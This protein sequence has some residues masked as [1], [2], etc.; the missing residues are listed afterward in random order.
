MGQFVFIFLSGRLGGAKASCSAR[1]VTVPCSIPWCFQAV[2]HGQLQP[3]WQFAS[4]ACG[5]LLGSGSWLGRAGGVQQHTHHLIPGRTEPKKPSG[6]QAPG[7]TTLLCPTQVPVPFSH[8]HLLSSQS[9][10]N[11][12]CGRTGG[13]RWSPREVFLL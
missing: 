5:M 1:E 8:K 6:G 13:R 10:Q 7:R 12:L 3:P 11:Q 9:K 4:Q 2:P